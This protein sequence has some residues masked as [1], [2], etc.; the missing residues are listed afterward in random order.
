VD[1]LRRSIVRLLRWAVI[2]M[3]VFFAGM[4][5]QVRQLSDAQDRT[6]DQLHA[7]GVTVDDIGGFVDDLQ[8]VT[9]EEAARNQQVTEVLATVPGIASDTDTLVVLVCQLVPDP[10]QCLAPPGP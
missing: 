8:T 9:P 7:I 2:V 1:D 5:W 4:Q 3:A 10:N 6:D